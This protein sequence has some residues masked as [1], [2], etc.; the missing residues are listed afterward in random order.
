[1]IPSR[2]APVSRTPS[3]VSGP[4]IRTSELKVVKSPLKV[5][6]PLKTTGPENAEEPKIATPS[7]LT[8]LGL[9]LGFG[10]GLGFGLRAHGSRACRRGP[11]PRA[12]PH[13]HP[14]TTPTP[15]PTLTLTLTL[16]LVVRS[17]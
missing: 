11:P 12:N 8:W 2:S 13:P 17:P 1:M 5:A 16:T 3:S 9:W 10:L 4:L 6:L 15:T 7:S 14:T